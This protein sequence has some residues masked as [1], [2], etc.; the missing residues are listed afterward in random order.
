[1][2]IAPTSTSQSTTSLACKSRSRTVALALQAQPSSSQ[3]HT[4]P[5]THMPTSPSTTATSHSHSQAQLSGTVPVEAAQLQLPLVA[6]PQLQPL[7]HQTVVDHL[8]DLVLHST[9]NAVVLASLAQ[10]PAHRELARRATIGTHSA[11]KRTAQRQQRRLLR[12]IAKASAEIAEGVG[13]GLRMI[14]IWCR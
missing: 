14:W 12:C 5:L 8:E 10:P 3:E 1:V 11:C 6:L 9:D 4:R 2:S 13:T 7:P